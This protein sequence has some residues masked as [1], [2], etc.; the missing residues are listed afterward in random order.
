[1][2]ARSAKK[3]AGHRGPGAQPVAPHIRG[4]A[5]SLENMAAGEPDLALDIGRPHRLHRKYN[6]W[7]VRTKPADGTE[8]QLACFVEV[9][10][11]SY[12]LISP[13]FV[14]RLD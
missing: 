9:L 7:Q 8:R 3:Q 13:A 2:S 5:F 6:V 1:M 12:G 4:K 10:S 11:R 14:S